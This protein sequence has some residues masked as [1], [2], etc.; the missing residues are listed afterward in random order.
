MSMVELFDQ[1]DPPKGGSSSI[2]KTSK[3]LQANRKNRAFQAGGYIEQARPRKH[4]PFLLP[5]LRV[6]WALTQGTGTIE[7][8]IVFDIR[9]SL[10]LTSQNA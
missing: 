4:K 1:H 2:Y 8:E 3:I 9:V 5:T 10:R 6:A 7:I